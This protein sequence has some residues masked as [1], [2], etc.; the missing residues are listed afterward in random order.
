[1]ESEGLGE[2]VKA[3][4]NAPCDYIQL[5][6]IIQDHPPLKASFNHISKVPLAM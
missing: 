4:M 3:V 2:N 6:W 5:T 1:M